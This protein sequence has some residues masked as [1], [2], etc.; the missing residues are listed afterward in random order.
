MSAP[1]IAGAAVRR[2]RLA[3]RPALQVTCQGSCM[4][5]PQSQ[6][7]AGRLGVDGSRARR[8]AGALPE[9]APPVSS[10]RRRRLT[11]SPRPTGSGYCRSGRL[12]PSRAGRRSSWRWSPSGRCAHVEREQLAQT[13]VARSAPGG[14]ALDDVEDPARRCPPPAP[15]RLAMMPDVPAGIRRSGR[16]IPARRPAPRS[17]SVS[18]GQRSGS[19]RPAIRARTAS[20][21]ASL[22]HPVP[23]R[24]PRGQ[25]AWSERAAREVDPRRQATRVEIADAVVPP[26]RHP[27]H[28][29][30]WPSELAAARFPAGSRSAPVASAPLLT[31]AAKSGWLTRRGCIE[32]CPRAN[33][34]PRRCRTGSAARSL[35]AARAFVGVLVRAGSPSARRPGRLL[36]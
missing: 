3:C 25:V 10:V 13:R 34:R 26:M 33:G 36:P 18:P 27:Q 31:S 35:R 29:V 11:T 12:V 17:A 1:G 6:V 28:G 30:W 21:D 2:P 16:R 15:A 9:T 24:I 19:R 22:R 7:G 23:G 8:L 20:R 14:C 5:R 32:G 4:D